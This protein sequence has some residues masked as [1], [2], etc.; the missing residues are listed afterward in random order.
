LFSYNGIIVRLCDNTCQH[1]FVTFGV[2][3]RRQLRQI[4]FGVISVPGVDAMRPIG[5]LGG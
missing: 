4:K 2:S 5:G 1:L 3:R